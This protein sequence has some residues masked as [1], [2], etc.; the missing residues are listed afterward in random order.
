MTGDAYLGH[1][2]RAC[3]CTRTGGAMELNQEANDRFW[4]SEREEAFRNSGGGH[5]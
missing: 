4:R 2:E 1:R 3:P 5:W